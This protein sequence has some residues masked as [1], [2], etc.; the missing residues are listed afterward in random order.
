MSDGTAVSGSLFS[1]ATNFA[2][3]PSPLSVAIG[4]VNGDDRP[5][6]AVANFVSN[7]TSVLLG[8]GDGTFQP[9]A[10]F[11]AGT[12]PASVA[13]GDV[14]GDGKA[15]LAVANQGGNVSVL[16]GNG[17]G[18]FQAARNFVVGGFARSVAIGDINGDGKADL[19]V[20]NFA[21]NNVSVLRSNGDGTFQDATNFVAGTNPVSV[22]IGDLN[23][24]G[25]VDLA[26]ANT[27]S[28]NVSVLL[29]YGDDTFQAAMN[30]AAGTEPYFVAIGD[31]NGDGKA[32]LAVANFGNNTVSV[33]LSNGDG[34]FQPAANLAVGTQPISVAIGDLNGDGKADLAV[35][36]LGNNNVSVLLGNGDGTFQAA[37]NFS[38]G[39]KSGSVAI[40]D[41]NGDGERDLAVA[42]TDSNNV[43]VLLNNSTNLS[44]TQHTTVNITAV[45]DPPVAHN[46]SFNT[47]ETTAIAEATTAPTDVDGGPQNVIA[48]NGG[49]PQFGTPVALPSGALLTFNADR[50]FFYDPNHVFDT[51]PA[52]GSGASNT[53][54]TDSFSYTLFGGSTATVLVTIAGVDS[55]DILFDA[56][57]GAATL[58][59]GIGNDIYVV[60]NAG[61]AII[62]NPNAGYD[63]VYS[64]VNF[65]L[66]ANVE[67]LVLF[68]PATHATANNGGDVL[69]DNEL[70]A[71]T[72][73]GGSGD[74]IYLIRHAGDHIVEQ[75]G[76][77]TD[78]AYATVD[79][80]TL[81]P[82]VEYGELLGSATQIT[83]NNNGCVL[84]D[85][86]SLPST[87]I[88]GSGDDTYLIRNAGDHIVEQPGGGTDVAIV[89]VNGYTL[90]ANVEYG[91]LL[92]SAT[93]I[94]GNNNGCVL[95]DNPSLPSTL[96]GGS[97]NDTYLIRNAGDH[98][99]EQPGGGTD[100]AIVMAD[101]YTLDANVEYG[102]LLGSATQITGNNTGSVLFDNPSLA[103]TLTGGSGNDFY[104]IRH[105]GD[106]IVEQPG[107]GT[108]I[109][110]VMADGYT[111]DANVEYL[112]L[113]GS[114]TQ[115]AANNG[116]AILYANPTL[117]STLSGTG[118][119][120]AF[121]SGLGNDIFTAGGGNDQFVFNPGFGQDLITNFVPGA[122]ATHDDVLFDHAILADFNSVMS[123]AAEVPDGPG[124]DT[125]IIDPNNPNDTLTLQHVAKATLAAGDFGFF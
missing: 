16:L 11:A 4:D 103:S 104:L 28:N 82:N 34:T 10:N 112:K 56:L 93:Q 105:A 100:T 106:H 22:A 80:Y 41:L 39:M 121:L 33:L 110:I 9:E 92:G 84:F 58:A 51:L 90:D 63:T 122:G 7:N 94:T 59:G 64:Y 95:F 17:D 96:I 97:G 49:A 35:A 69:F 48:V 3:G 13:I 26:V 81:D 23:G 114:A 19:A 38:A 29:G 12:N 36:N 89:T 60:H 115:A 66:P 119:H 52:P 68:G 102:E 67:Q 43:S 5:D 47:A 75:P 32:D 62:E 61:D 50:S 21:S 124:V 111:L 42:N 120:A 31:V 70:L 113:D 118:G 123:H 73:T 86:P 108:D 117:G 1:A 2:A 72:L 30:F 54:A 77:G 57:E 14:N 116:G 107:G 99:V 40:G 88:G 55:N 101:G 65:A 83:G 20:A 15:D 53:H 98:I 87:L 74:D 44:A 125:V 46:D 27:N 37:T 78:I 6:L 45:N 24:D 25:K 18:T 109:A 8:N 85:N 91:E 79:G 76:G 71:S